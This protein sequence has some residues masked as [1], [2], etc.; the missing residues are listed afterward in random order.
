MSDEKNDTTPEIKPIAPKAAVKKP[1]LKKPA[2]NPFV[3]PAANKFISSK[4]GGGM[5]KGK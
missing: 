2:L 1:I 5:K 4:A 3:N